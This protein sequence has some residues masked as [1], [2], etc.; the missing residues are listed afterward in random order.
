MPEPITFPGGVPSEP[1]SGPAREE[2]EE[3]G[4]LSA[5]R[6]LLVLY[7]VLLRQKDPRRIL[8]LIATAAPA[9]ASCRTQ[10][11]VFDGQWSDL[12]ISDES[13]IVLDKLISKLQTPSQGGVLPLSTAM[14]GYAYPLLSGVEASGFL[15]VRAEVIPTQHEQFLL[16]ALA[17]QGGVAVA[18]A[19]L[20]ARERDHAA[21]L[22]EAILALERNVAIQQRLI[23]VAAA[24]EG[25]E[26]IAQA[27]HDLSGCPTAIEDRYGHLRAWAGGDRPDPYPRQS[28]ERRSA[29]LRQALAAEGPV[30]DG[31]RLVSVAST[32][33]DIMAVLVLFDQEHRA[34]EPEQV[35]L[36]YAS[37]VLA[38][39]VAHLRSQAVTDLQLRG[40]LVLELLAGDDEIS[41]QNRALALG[42]DLERPHW[43]VLV[44]S[45]HERNSLLDAVRR[46]ARDAAVGSLLAARLGG[47]VLLADAE[48]D[49]NHFYSTLSAELHVTRCRVGVGGRCDSYSDFSR[50]L[51]EA[52]QALRLQGAIDDQ[53]GLTVF[54]DL[55]IYQLFCD[56]PDVGSLERLVQRWLGALLECDAR[57]GSQ[58]VATLSAY[59][60]SGGN[61]QAAAQTLSVH[62][63]TVKYRLGRIRD[64]SGLNLS[65]ADTH[66]HL[67]LATRALRARNA[68]QAQ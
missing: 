32:G 56:L 60:E 7:A 35:L 63:S 50:S 58:L 42:Y 43:V 48:P 53:R 17:Q 9:L 47:V 26:G 28:P 20:H 27:V 29:L 57:S 12:L 6:G 67:Q 55:G 18:N 13:Q 16:R 40:E 24:R 8:H 23:R 41:A 22:Q 65:D 64:V 39:E 34:G 19:I 31:D 62:R 49:W 68:L 61:Y 54:G 38:M 14:W 51:R 11:V 45:R 2:R 52:A 36:G 10:G 66:F 21:Q 46:V 30:R 33:A 4:Q 59:L 1:P 37:M 15:V 3:G 5:L 25:Q 44:E